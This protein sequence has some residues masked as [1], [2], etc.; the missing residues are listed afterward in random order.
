MEKV[1][2]IRVENFCGLEELEVEVGE[3]G[4]LA[5]GD[6]GVGKTSLINALRFA[7]SGRLGEEAIRVGADKASVLVRLD[8]KTVKRVL[9]KGKTVKL[10]STDGATYS[11]PV[12]RLRR[13]LGTDTLE[14]LR[15]LV[16]TDKR[17]VKAAVLDAMP[18][19]VTVEQLRK[20]WPKCPADF[21]VSGHG[22]EVISRVRERAYA[23]RADANKAAKTAAANA[24]RLEQEAAAAAAKAPQEAPDVDAMA[25]AATR[26]REAVVGLESRA[27]QAEQQATATESQRR[28]V[29]EM[30]ERAA[31]ARNEAGECKP[32][33]ELANA[34]DCEAEARRQVEKLKRELA[35]A[36]GTLAKAT[37]TVEG[38]IAHNARVQQW[39][40]KADAHARQARELEMALDQAAIEPVSPDEIARA[41]EYE[42]QM[43]QQL[44]LAKEAEKARQRA[45]QAAE[46]LA[47]A[48]AE[49]TTTAERAAY[50]DS[51]VRALTDD[52]PAE[53]LQS[54]GGIQGLTI[55][56]EDIYLDG[57]N[58][59]VLNGAERAR[60]AVQIAKRAIE[61]QEPEA[62]VLICD[63]LECLSSKTKA[64]FIEEATSGGWQLFGS[65]VSDDER[66]VLIPLGK[67]TQAEAAE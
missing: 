31:R 26:A 28:R 43:T 15:L 67:L 1:R 25:E 66:L 32:P 6:N 21:D 61:R 39:M 7:L 53:L 58:F 59:S 13:L 2:A 11:E 16:E 51:V 37:A 41:R 65:R 45:A 57:V 54:S 56:G 19:E 17:K 64:A 14:P 46:A 24:E 48:K 20:W 8:T 47:K 36:E 22:L 27:R 52:A 44:E 42:Q 10:L 9:G 30:R 4:L 12:T 3:D 50:L 5:E 60:L 18:V 23:Q 34:V 35:D 33:A 38:I 63:G 55:Q 49:S 62:R 40:D 29:A